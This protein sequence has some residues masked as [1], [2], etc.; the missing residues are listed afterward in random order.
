MFPFFAFDVSVG[1]TEEQFKESWTRP[2]AVDIDGG[3]TVV[4]KARM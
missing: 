4:A 1:V 3:T 2:G